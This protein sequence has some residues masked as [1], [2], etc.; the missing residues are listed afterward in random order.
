LFNAA[1]PGCALNGSL[2]T[3]QCVYVDPG[4]IPDG[5]GH[6]YF[7]NRT[8]YQIGS[9]AAFGEASY[10]FSPEFRVTGG[11]RYTDDNKKAQ[12]FEPGLFLP[13]SGLR[14]LPLQKASFTEL[15]GRLNAEWSPEL[16]FTDKSL[17]YA[18]YARGYKGGGFNPPQS[19]GQNLFPETYDPEFINA[20]EVGSKN[21]L[22]GGQ[23]ILNATG[24]Y[25]DYKGYQVSQIIQRTSVNVNIDAKIW[26]AELE[27]V[28]E[29]V[30]GLRFNGQLGLL[31]TKLGDTDSLDLSNLTQGNPGF[32]TV[33]NGGTFS[34]CIA[35]TAQVAQLQA[36]INA[37]V[38][39]AIAMTGVPGRTDLGICQ[40][41][42]APGQ[43]LSALV[44]ITP[45]GGVPANLD[46]NQLPNS[47]H[48]TLALGAQYRFELGN[49]WAATPRVD[50]YAQGKSYARIFNAV[51][52]R[53]RSYT[54]ANLSLIVDNEELGWNV[55]V[56]VK[57]LADKTVV[58][59]QY[60]TDDTSGLFTNIFLTEPRLYG[61]SVSKA[62]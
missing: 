33:K 5:S 17:F 24:F 55:Q 48:Y 28:W 15:T 44:A 47:P 56:Y 26:G 42:F 30:P 9:Y 49:G 16:G 37:G 12:P 51:N 61:V 60:L 35:P 29:P 23:L 14:A 40:G 46:N 54:N 58:T 31:D 62:F 20:F 13:G 8:R 53:L 25:Y 21:T 6:N 22:M 1:T 41:A 19:A 4:A 2:T 34:N 45:G 59:D 7:D 36:L 39:P 3:P 57:N 11:L 32:V 18:S 27:A 43:P 50:F 52:D 10:E 38:L